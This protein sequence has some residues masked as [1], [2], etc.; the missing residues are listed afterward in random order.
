MPIVNKKARKLIQVLQSRINK[1]E[2]NVVRLLSALTL[3]N[4]LQSS[5]GLDTDFINNPFHKFFTAAKR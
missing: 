3:E 4:L 5:F 2:F 1:E